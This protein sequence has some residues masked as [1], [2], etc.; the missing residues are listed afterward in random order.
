MVYIEVN[1]NPLENIHMKLDDTG[2]ATQF[3]ATNSENESSEVPLNDAI[4]KINFFGHLFSSS[5]LNLSNSKFAP[6][7]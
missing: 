5:K 3:F 1:E 7:R 2:T 6:S 4:G